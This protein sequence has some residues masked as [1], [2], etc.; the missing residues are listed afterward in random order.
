MLVSI[1]EHTK[2]QLEVCCFISRV[3]CKEEALF[4][5]WVALRAA[6]VLV[7]WLQFLFLDL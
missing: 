3:T 6:L 7:F 2:Q 4:F 1:L 5:S